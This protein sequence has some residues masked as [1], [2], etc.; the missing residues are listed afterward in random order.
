M[1]VT[2]E[3]RL[4]ELGIE[5]PEQLPVIGSYR[6]AKR[7]RGI[8]YIAGHVSMTLEHS[9]LIRGKVGAD[10]TLEEAYEAARVCAL[11]MLSTLRVET[12]SLDGVACIPE[13]CD[14]LQPW[15]TPA[16]CAQR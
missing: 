14:T 12:G 13:R 11:H 1:Y 6:L 9:D 4:H 5:L 15:T 10:L 3:T 7:H 16:S 2:P 8:V